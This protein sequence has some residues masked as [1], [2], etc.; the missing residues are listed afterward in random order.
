M[1]EKENLK[2]KS[3]TKLEL[4]TPNRFYEKKLTQQYE[5][6]K[7]KLEI[8]KLRAENEK[9]KEENVLNL[10]EDQQKMDNN[11]DIKAELTKI[12]NKE[13]RYSKT[14]YND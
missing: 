8:E 14:Y 2:D 1:S 4:D 9:D 3:L 12:T 10:K 5:L 11:E 7:I 6:E 13:M